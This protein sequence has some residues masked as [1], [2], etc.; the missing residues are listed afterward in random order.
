[1]YEALAKRHP[2]L[3]A[4]LRQMPHAKND[5]RDAL[6]AKRRVLMADWAD[7]CASDRAAHLPSNATGSEIIPPAQK[8][9][10]NR[11]NA[12]ALE[13]CRYLL[14]HSDCS[15]VAVV[16]ATAHT[17][18]LNLRKTASNYHQQSLL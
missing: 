12:S 7:F 4:W 18:S 2:K 10:S 3:R 9:I 13:T 6:V 5:Q 8:S 14:R 15:V 16:S 11:H 17:W 1:M